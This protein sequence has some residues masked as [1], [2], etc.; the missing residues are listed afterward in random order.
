[1]VGQKFS[2]KIA[3]KRPIAGRGAS[4]GLCDDEILP[5]ICPTCQVLEQSSLG[6]KL[7]LEQSF[8][9]KLE[10]K[11]VRAGDGRLLCMG[12]FSIF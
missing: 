9:A 5:V 2:S 1:M 3:L 4:N 12:S 6:A 11:R 10:A 7:V 8:G